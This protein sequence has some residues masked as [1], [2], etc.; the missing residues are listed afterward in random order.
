VQGEF[1]KWQPY[2]RI[3]HKLKLQDQEICYIGD[4]VLDL[5]VLKAVGFSVAVANAREEVKAVADYVTVARGGR[6][7]VREVIDL[8][9]KRQ[10]KFDVVIEKLS[11]YGKS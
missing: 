5:P 2:L 1:D 6:G 4:D 8:I 7:A 3:R 9:L 11:K 10:G